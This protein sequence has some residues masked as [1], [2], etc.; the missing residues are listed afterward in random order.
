VVFGDRAG[1][2]S[3]VRY[4]AL[5]LIQIAVSA[6]AVYLL[7]HILSVSSPLL[8][9]LIKAVVDTILF[10]VSFRVQHKWVF[11]EGKN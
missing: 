5:A 11:A 7:E 10:F 2:K 3:M 9:T 1:K 8:S 4:Y 6:G